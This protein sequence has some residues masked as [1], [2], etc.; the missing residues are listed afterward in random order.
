M[1]VWEWI[2]FVVGA[3]LILAG[4][5]VFVTAVIGNFRFQF[6]LNRMQAAALGDTMGIFLCLLGVMV[7]AG[8][9]AMSL[10]LILIIVFF[11]ISSPV[12]SHLLVKMEITT[13]EDLHPE[14]K[15]VKK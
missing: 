14:N 13:G 7:L 15:V 12:A 11:W 9:D 10:K 2:R 4:L 1:N 5:F 3:L 6:V 8:W